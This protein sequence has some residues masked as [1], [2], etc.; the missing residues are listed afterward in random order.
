MTPEAREIIGKAADHIE[1]HGLLFAEWGAQAEDPSTMCCCLV[2]TFRYVAGRY[3]DDALSLC[4]PEVEE[5]ID[6][7]NRATRHERRR[8]GAVMGWE[9]PLAL[10]QWSDQWADVEELDDGLV[11]H[12]DGDRSHVV[13]LLRGLVAG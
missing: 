8:L 5:A 13:E 2:G 7:V 9:I 11:P 4:P 6:V 3:P 1:T 10:T 12:T